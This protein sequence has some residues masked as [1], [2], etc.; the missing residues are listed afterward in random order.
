MRL[1]RRRVIRINRV[2][3]RHEHVH[4]AVAVA[5]EPVRVPAPL[6][7]VHDVVG[8]PLRAQDVVRWIRAE[9]ARFD[10]VEVVARQGGVVHHVAVEGEFGSVEPFLDIGQGQAGTALVKGDALV[11][12]HVFEGAERGWVLGQLAPGLAGAEVQHDEAG[13]A[14]VAAVDNVGYAFAG[15]GGVGAHVE[16]DVVHVG[17]W[18]VDA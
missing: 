6:T 5:A 14:F 12:G 11:R 9:V 7:Q 15:G 3:L 1:Q 13:A 17:V 10:A 4:G 8:R 16:A 2:L 18:I